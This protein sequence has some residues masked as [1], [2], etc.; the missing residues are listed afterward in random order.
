MLFLLSLLGAIRTMQ[1]EVYSL[2]G[3]EYSDIEQPMAKMILM[4][5]YIG[6]SLTA[7]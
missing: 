2:V 4:A 3:Q 1:I 5:V 7:K 6:P